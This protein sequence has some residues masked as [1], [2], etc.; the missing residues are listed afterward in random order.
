MVI[1]SLHFTKSCDSQQLT[2]EMYVSLLQQIII[3]LSSSLVIFLIISLVLSTINTKNSI[4][5]KFFTVIKY[6]NILSISLIF[7]V[8]FFKFNFYLWNFKEYS[9]NLKTEYIFDIQLLNR[10]DFTD[11]TVNGSIISDVVTLLSLS[12]GLICI[13]LLGDKNLTKSISNLNLFSIF[14]W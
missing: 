14:F 11:I 6:L 3:Y 8:I 2:F 4:F 1:K 5:K 12:S 13:H 10:F 7:L 9:D